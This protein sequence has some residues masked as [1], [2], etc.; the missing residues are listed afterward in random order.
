MNKTWIIVAAL[1]ASVAQAVSPVPSDAG[2]NWLENDFMKTELAKARE[3]GSRSIA[4]A[5]VV[6]E[7]MMTA[8]FKKVRDR[9]LQIKSADEID[10][11][12][13]ELDKNYDSY[14]ADL[15]FAAAQIIPFKTMKGIVWRVVPVIEK[16]DAKAVHSALLASV[17]GLAAG[18]R[19]YLPTD[20]WEAGFAYVTEPMT[21]PKG[22]GPDRFTSAEELQ[23]FFATQ[24]YPAIFKASARI[25]KLSFADKP[26]VADAKI[27][28]GTASFQD[29]LDRFRIVG[30]PERHAALAALHSSLGSISGFL[31]VRVK[32]LFAASKDVG[33]L[34]GFDGFAGGVD[35]VP[36][37]KRVATI[38]KHSELFTLNEM[39]ANWLR[40]NLKHLRE[41]VRQGRI[42]WEEIKK[43]PADEFAALDS[44]RILPFSREIELNMKN[45]EA[46]VNG[47]TELRS[48]V[49]GETV[50]VDLPAFFEKLPEDYKKA[51][52]RDLDLK[53]FLATGF[54][55]GAKELTKNGVKYRNYFEG[56]PTAWDLSVYKTVLPDVKTNA[57]I[58]KAARILGQS[59]GGW[60]AAIPLS[61]FV[62]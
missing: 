33:K 58:E 20:Q 38:K 26:A 45:L 54:D 57:D 50:K 30:E 37:S 56:R 25:G 62:L 53:A 16:A 47:P 51:K 40:R 28:Y 6:G 18:F 49:T 36:A 22:T 11:L 43:R 52:G 10:P 9:L 13:D 42:V 61:A 4:Q 35:G 19:I 46:L 23:Q 14:P 1:A 34:Y 3:R 32:G 2:Y 15:Q 8:E 59:W 12:I 24:V 7:S 60:A 27:L 39:G 21:A 55:K 17:R 48:L 41:A 44:A 29:D 5:R 31:A